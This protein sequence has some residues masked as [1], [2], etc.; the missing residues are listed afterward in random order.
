[1]IN[2]NISTDDTMNYMQIYHNLMMFYNHHSTKSIEFSE[3]YTLLLSNYINIIATTHYNVINVD[4]NEEL[5]V[6]DKDFVQQI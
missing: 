4:M 1:M 3:I 2:A 6:I 5:F